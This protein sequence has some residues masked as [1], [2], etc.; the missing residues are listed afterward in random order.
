MKS[1]VIALFLCVL[2]FVSSSPSEAQL[3]TPDANGL[4]MGHLHLGAKDVEGMNKFFI[5]LGGTPTEIRADL[6]EFPGIFVIV[7]QADP[8]PTGGTAGS[9]VNH[10][11]FNVKN[12]QESKAKWDAAGLQWEPNG[13]PT[14]GYLVG[15]GGIRVEIIE[16]TA[17]TT[18]IKFHHVHFF[19]DAP[20]T[21]MQAWYVKTFGAVAGKRGNL[22]AADLP[23]VNL[24]FSKSDTPVV[25]TKGRSLDHIGF[26]VKNLEQFTK[27]L[28][29]R[30]IT[31]DRPYSKVAKPT[32]TTATAFLTDP[33]GTYVELT[34]NL[35]PA[36]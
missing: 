27:A 19:S 8:P 13:R 29:S 34:E 32:T 21:D 25:G 36:K 15:P 9:T 2:I 1:I 20:P 12:M 33:W 5:A 4:A 35:A 22:D 6:I 31:F 17:I 11:G 18:P 24:T 28:E 30:G 3:A 23:G 16:N 14:Q 7:R 10:I 26:D